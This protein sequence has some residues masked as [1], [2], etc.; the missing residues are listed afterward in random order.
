[1]TDFG[2][3]A[4]APDVRSDESITLGHT[5]RWAA[6]EILNGERPVSNESYTHWFSTVVIKVSARSLT[7]ITHVIVDFL[8]RGSRLRL[9]VAAA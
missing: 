4:D 2:L 9:G 6:P 1:M 7:V 5:V 3:A 8:A